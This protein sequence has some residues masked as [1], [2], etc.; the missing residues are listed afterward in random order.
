MAHPAGLVHTAAFYRGDEE[1][2]AEVLPFIMDGLAY[3]DSVM[4]TVPADKLTLLRDAL[5][6]AAARV[7]MTDM[8]EIGRNPAN[9]FAR[10]AAELAA[11]RD[12][13]RVWAVAEPVWPGR[14]PEEYPACVQNEALFNAAV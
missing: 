1:Y 13:R 12:D 6:D 7:A 9:T 14:T 8:G 4:V 10:F 11:E 3:E 5:G 2:L